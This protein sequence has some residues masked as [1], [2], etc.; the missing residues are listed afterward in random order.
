[1]VGVSSMRAI[2]VLAGPTASGKTALALRLAQEYPIEIVSADAS[3]VYR[4]LDIGTDKPSPQERAAVPHHLIDIVDP[5]EPFSVA[6]YLERAEEAIAEVLQ[7]GKIPLVVGGTG[8]YI[9]T[10]SEGLYE[11]P[12]RDAG[13]QWQLEREL[14]QRGLEALIAELQAASPEDARRAGRNPRR[15]LRALEVLRR[16]GIPPSRFPRRKPRFSY[17]KAILW[18]AFEALKPRLLART[19]RH[20]ER[21]LVEEVRRLFERYPTPPVALGAIGYKELLG[22]L[23]G[24]YG[25]EEARQRIEQ[26]TIAYARRQYTWFRKEPGDVAFLEALAEEAWPLLRGWF[27]GY[28]VQGDC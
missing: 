24:E 23:R 21:G 16:T 2:P 11:I 6:Q 22:Y 12:P 8:Y 13:V 15:V 10:L 26:N 17:R 7:R 1:M 20:F 14:E 19:A 18:P 27:G 5:D 28:R 25:L 4:G 3:L 9:R